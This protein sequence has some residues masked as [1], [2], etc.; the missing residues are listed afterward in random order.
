MMPVIRKPRDDEED[1]DADEAAWQRLREGVEIHDQHDG[2]GAQT[3]DIRPILGGG[4]GQSSAIQCHVEGAE[5]A[6]RGLL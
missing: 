1:V 2:D 5:R 6:P 4:R 3:I